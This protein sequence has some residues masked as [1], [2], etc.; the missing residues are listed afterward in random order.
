MTQRS[1][2][3]R[4]QDLRISKPYQTTPTTPPSACLWPMQIPLYLMP[5]N[6]L[7][8]KTPLS[9]RATGS[10]RRNGAQPLVPHDATETETIKPRLQNGEDRLQ[11]PDDTIATPADTRYGQPHN[12]EDMQNTASLTR[13]QRKKTLRDIQKDHGGW[14]PWALSPADIAPRHINNYSAKTQ[15]KL[16]HRPRRRKHVQPPKPTLQA[17]FFFGT[18][19]PPK[20]GAGWGGG[21]QRARGNEVNPAKKQHRFRTCRSAVF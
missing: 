20:R 4:N 14:C 16:R 13:R 17:I 21:A 19:L 7:K 1:E 3:R 10:S 2:R 8:L 6:H 18:S 9:R 5:L 15:I 11:D 12:R